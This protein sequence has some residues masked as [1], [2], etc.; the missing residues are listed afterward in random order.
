MSQ[1]TYVPSEDDYE[2]QWV[3]F[4]ASGKR[5]GRLASR[6]AKVLRGKHKPEF[7]P[8]LDCGDGAIVINASDIELTGSKEIDEGVVR[9]S[10]Y[11]G[12][13]KEAKYDEL[14]EK[15]PELAVREAIHGMLPSNRLG[16]SI[17]K[18]L[19]VYGGPDHEQE[20][21]QPVEY[22]WDNE[23]VPRTNDS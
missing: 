3:L 4:D 6:V 13:L 19:R 12:G 23:Q 17:R 16:R 15:K 1:K 14:R 10:G 9:H 21:Q 8:H 18:H 5:L 11:P 7:T 2:R 22:D 20:A